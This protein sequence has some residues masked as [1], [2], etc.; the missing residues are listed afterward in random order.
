M[1]APR[2]ATCRTS[3]DTATPA[4]PAATTTPDTPSTAT[5]PTPSPPT[6]ADGELPPLERGHP[7]AAGERL[8]SSG[9]QLRIE[10]LDSQGDQF[11]HARADEAERNCVEHPGVRGV[12]PQRI[13]GAA[14][15][16]AH[17]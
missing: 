9:P 12:L 15:Q 11:R 4:P 17:V 6:S 16:L 1:P 2:C 5:P 10:A 7:P 13:R 14:D 3:L 8:S